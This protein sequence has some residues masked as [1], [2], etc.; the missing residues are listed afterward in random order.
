MGI[1]REFRDYVKIAIYE[2]V[3]KGHPPDFGSLQRDRADESYRRA[4]A[5]LRIATR[6]TNDASFACF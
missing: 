2:V 1:I 5:T 3:E 6:A 4:L